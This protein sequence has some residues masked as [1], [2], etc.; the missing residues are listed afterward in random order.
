MTRNDKKKGL[1]V[2]L[3]Q[4]GMT[5]FE[6]TENGAQL[7]AEPQLRDY[8]VGQDVELEMGRSA[9]VFSQCSYNGPGDPPDHGRNWRKMRAEISNANAHPIRVRV[10]LGWSGEW[11]AKWPKHK[12]EVKDGNLIVEVSVPANATETFD[13]RMRGTG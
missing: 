4:G 2:A 5:V 1:G 7:V 6:P 12:T 13:F 11:E 9:Q 10:A 8:A 3:P